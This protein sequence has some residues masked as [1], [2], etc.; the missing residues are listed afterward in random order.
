M[1]LCRRDNG[2]GMLLKY[3]GISSKQGRINPGRYSE[4]CRI[5]NSGVGLQKGEK[6]SIY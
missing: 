1:N 4:F 3:A 6:A 5:Q 2:K